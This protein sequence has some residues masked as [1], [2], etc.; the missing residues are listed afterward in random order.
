M[1]GII[2]VLLEDFLVERL[3]AKDYEAMIAAC[4]LKTRDPFQVHQTYPDDDLFKILL[5]AADRLSLGLSDV[6]RHFGEFCF[7]CLVRR[8]PVFVQ[9]YDHPKPFIQ[10]VQRIIHVEVR[11]LYPDAETP[12]FRYQDPAPDRLIIEYESK[13][14][15][16]HFMEGI[17]KG[18][19]THF[20]CPI[21]VRQSR[22]VHT[23]HPV[24]E[25][26]LI[27][28]SPTPPTSG[29]PSHGNPPDFR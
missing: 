26:E 1:K 14:R 3:G 6:L 9:P 27:F 5:N 2:F 18:V 29:S 12:I 24:C 4:G 16:C 8:Y 19:E 20:R 10:S 25:F 7:P 22:C 11:K 13:R 21:R 15:L 28:A 23:G 17:I